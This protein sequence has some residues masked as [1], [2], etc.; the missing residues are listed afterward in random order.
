MP[1][2]QK[3]SVANELINEINRLGRERSP[4]EMGVARV[5]KSAERLLESLP[6][7]GHSILGM[8]AALRMDPVEARRHHEM[9][10]NLAGAN[11]KHEISQFAVSLSKLGLNQEAMQ[12]SAQAVELEP[13]NLTYLRQ[14]VTHALFA[15][16]FRVAGRWL[17]V[18]RERCPTEPHEHADLLVDQLLPIAVERDITDEDLSSEAKELVQ[19]ALDSKAR[20]MSWDIRVAED[21]ETKWI[22]YRLQVAASAPV[23]EK[24][25]DAY[26]AR[27]AEKRQPANIAM[28]MCFGFDEAAEKAHGDHAN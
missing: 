24:L 18:W 1:L 12:K 22:S 25:G 27:L 19:I 26:V 23:V 6:S 16:R 8:V 2:P 7:Q 11:R 14:L 4:N 20:P 21:D 17:D 10:V 15:G 5:Q 3:Q 13:E 9:A 28:S